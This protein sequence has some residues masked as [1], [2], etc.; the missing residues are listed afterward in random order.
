MIA[1]INCASILKAHFATLKR[2]GDGR[3]LC[4]ADIFLF[5]GVPALI[6]T[7]VVWALD[8]SIGREASNFLATVFSIF[9]GLLLNLLVIIFD[10][11]RTTGE[12][13]AL[14]ATSNAE[15]R[16]KDDDRKNLTLRLEILNETFSNLSYSILISVVLLMLLF[17]ERLFSGL[18]AVI[19]SFA[20]CFIIGN[21][22]LT[23]LMV[24][25][26][27]HALLTNEALRLRPK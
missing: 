2:P 17:A 27:V 12:Q 24:L 22:L 6:G 13:L 19:L 3:R 18:I 23:V 26:R 8:R 20:I 5:Y 14:L 25:K 4:W 11:V 10:Q 7:L 21:F 1:K 15:D 9:I 16:T